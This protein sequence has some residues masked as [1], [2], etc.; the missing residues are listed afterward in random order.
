M[1]G[2]GIVDVE[3]RG[4]GELLAKTGSFASSPGSKRRF[5]RK[6]VS[7]GELPNASSTDGP[8][9]SPTNF[10]GRPSSEQSARPRARG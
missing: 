7:F 3:L 2:K 5:S 9:I 10:T 1:G 8:T 4:R 6:E